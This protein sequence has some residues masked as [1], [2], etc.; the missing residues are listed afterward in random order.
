MNMSTYRQSYVSYRQIKI[1][2]TQSWL[3][4]INTVK[5]PIE[6]KLFR[7][8]TQ[9]HTKIL[10]QRTTSLKIVLIQTLANFIFQ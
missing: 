5:A 8:T 9:E 1:N 4:S 3:K 2:H 10:S 7:K 6:M